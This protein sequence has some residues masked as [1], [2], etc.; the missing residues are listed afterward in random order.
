MPTYTFQIEGTEEIVDVVFATADE[1]L[2]AKIDGDRV[3]LPDEYGGA[4]GVRRWDLGYGSRHARGSTGSGVILS[5]AL[6]VSPDQIPR[7]DG[8]IPSDRSP[9]RFHERWKGHL[10]E[11]G[12]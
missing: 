7:R 11:P 1:M 10:D 3:R 2:A 6:G 4:V 8:R 9:D 5:D 12:P